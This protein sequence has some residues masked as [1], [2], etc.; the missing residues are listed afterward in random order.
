MTQFNGGTDLRRRLDDLSS[1][2]RTRLPLSS[3]LSSLSMA[4]F[5]S[6]YDANSTTLSTTNTSIQLLLQKPL[7]F[8]CPLFREPNKTAKL[9]GAN[10]NCRPKTG[11]NYYSILN[12]MVLIRQSKRGHN[13]FAC[14]VTLHAKLNDFTVS[15]V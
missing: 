7:T 8:A 6:L 4:R 14:K 11:R 13:N 10:I 9:E 12:Y 1:T 5:I 3:V 2:R 15:S